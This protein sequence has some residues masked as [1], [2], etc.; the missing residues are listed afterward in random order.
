[1]THE[2]RKFFAMRAWIQG[3]WARDVV[4]SV[5]AD[6]CWLNVLTNASAEQQ[7]GTVQLGGPVLP[8]V[9]NAHSHAFQRAMVGL[10][11]RRGLSRGAGADDFWT[12]RERMYGVAHRITPDQLEAVASLLYAEL[13]R[14]GYTQVC[15][16]HYLHNAPDGRPYAD[17]LEMAQALVRAAQRVGIGL[18]LLPALYMRS[19][20]GSDRLADAQRRF[21]STPDGILRM[22]EAVNRQAAAAAASSMV[23]TTAATLRC[24][25]AVH[26]LRAVDAVPLQEMAAYARKVSLPVHIHIAEQTQEVEDCLVATGMRPIEWLLQHVAVDARWNLVHATHATRAELQ[27]VRAAGAAIVLCPTTEADLGDG[28]FDLRAYMAM[29][30]SWA[31]GSDSHAARQW[32]DELRL[33]EHVQRLVHRQR[34]VAAQAM[35]RES[36]AATLFDAATHGGRM[37][38]GQR[39]GTIEA[40]QRADFVIVDEQSAALLGIPGDDLLDALVFSSPAPRLSDVFVGGRPVVVQGELVGS[41]TS[42]SLW[43]A[44]ADDF[45]SVMQKLW[46]T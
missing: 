14:A 31:I 29:G 27:A 45:R 1:M 42:A 10:T 25:V 32:T 15:E 5:A 39:L 12:W 46:A 4:L 35:G 3:A 13:L 24:G 26:S 30:G 19:G 44:L 41:A 40:G 22:V 7:R 16:F 8:G 18:T 20:F 38:T 34:N 36:S 11:Q 23:A 33:L 28:I 17:P 9:V 2:V 43:P 37:A 6:G 21:A